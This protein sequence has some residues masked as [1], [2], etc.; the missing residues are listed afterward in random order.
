M[1]L[2][3]ATREHGLKSVWEWACCL[4]S[5]FLPDTEW[6]RSPSSPSCLAAR[7]SL[8]RRTEAGEAIWVVQ[9][10]GHSPIVTKP[11]LSGNS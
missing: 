9:H 2:H 8:L 1:D 3:W 10:S 5:F 4:V 11:S 6:K 7:M